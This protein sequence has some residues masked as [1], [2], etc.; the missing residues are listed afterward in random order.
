MQSNAQQTIVLPHNG[1]T[2]QETCPQGGFRHHRQ[3]YLLTPDEL[4]ATGL[5]N[6]ME[7][8]SI[9]FTIG[10]AQNIDA[11]GVLKIYLQNTG[12]EES[13][14]DTSWTQVS[15]MT[16]S[17]T[18][19]PLLRGEYE[20]QVRAVC[21]D[22][23]MYSAIATFSNTNLAGCNQP[24]DLSVTNIIDVSATLNWQSVES[25]DFSH[26]LVSYS[27]IDTADWT[28]D[29]TSLSSMNIAGLLSG[30]LYQWT[31]QAIC[32]GGFSPVSGGFFQT[33]SPIECTSPDNLSTGPISNTTAR[34]RWDEDIT[35]IRYDIQYRQLNTS[36][37]STTISFAD[38]VLLGGLSAGTYYEWRVRTVCNDG[39]GAYVSGPQFNTTGPLVCYPPNNLFETNLTDSTVT[40]HWTAPPG[41]SSYVLRYRLRNS[42]SWDN[43]IMPMTLVHNDTTV[44]PALTGN[45]T[46]PFSGLGINAFTYTGDGLYIAWEYSNPDSVIST[47]NTSLA[48]TEGTSLQNQLGLDSVE[49]ILCLAA[50]DPTMPPPVL[51]STRFRPETRLGSD[52]LSDS[53]EVVVAYTTGYH[54]IPFGNPAR[55]TAVV[56]NL[57]PLMKVLPVTVT[58][59]EKNSGALRFTETIQLDVEGDSNAL[60]VFSDWTPTIT[61]SDSVIVSIP[62]Q[63][64]ENVLINNHNSYLQV[65]NHTLLSYS[66]DSGPVTSA[67]FDTAAGLVLVRHHI[68]GCTKINAANI[69]LAPSSK[70]HSLYAVVLDADGTILSTSPA[71]IPDSTEIGTWHSFYFSNPPVLSD[72]DFYIGLAQPADNVNGYNPIGV[73]WETTVIRDSAYYRADLDGTNLTHH[74]SPGRLMIQAGVLP[75]SAVPVIE[76]DLSLCSGDMNTLTVASL[77]LRFASSVISFSSEFSNVQYSSSQVLGPPDV[78][79]GYGGD[80]NA[81]TSSTIDGQR[82]Y[83]QL[84][85]ADPAP[86][87][88]I[89][90]YETF[91]PGAVD[92]VYIRNPISGSLVAVYTATAE[93]EDP[94]SRDLTIE[95]PLTAFDVSEIRI[96][97]ASD[98]VSGFNTIDAVAIGLHESPADYASVEWSPGGEITTSIEVAAIG[99]YSVDVVDEDGCTGFAM[100]TVFTPDGVAPVIT[101]DGPVNICQGDEV[102][103]CSDQTS[104][105]TWNTGEVTQCIIV[106]SSGS[107]FVTHDDGTGCGLENSNTIVVQVNALP[108]VTI[109][110]D[111]LLCPGA[112]NT[113]D[114]GSYSS[115][116]WSTGDLTQTIM[117]SAPGEYTVTVTDANGCQGAGTVH[118]IDAPELTV[119]ITGDLTFCLGSST[120]LDA[121]MYSEYD[122]STGAM[123][124]TITVMSSGNYSVT[125]TDANGCSGSAS[126]TITGFIPPSPVITG[127]SGFCPGGET[128]LNAGPGYVLYAWSTS[129]NTQMITVDAAGTYTV[130]VTDN[131]SCTGTDNQNIIEFTPPEPVI[132]GT[133]SFC[134]GSATQL[135]AGPGYQSYL[136]STGDISQTIVVDTVDTFYVTVTDNNGCSGTDSAT[137]TDEG[138]IPEPPGPI[139]GPSSGLC[140]ETNVEY[141][142]EPVENAAFYVWTVPAGATIVS[143]QGST[144][145]F[146]DFD[147]GFTSGNIV[148]AA[149]NA[150][151]QSPSIDPTFLTVTGT[152]SMPSSIS[153][154]VTD[155]CAGDV[156]NYST[157]PVGDATGYFW[158]VPNNAQIT[159]GQGSTGITVSFLNGFTDGIICVSAT[160]DCGSS[161]PKCITIV[162]GDM[163]GDGVLDCEDNCPATFNPNQKDKD[164]D[165]VGDACDPCNNNQQGGNCNDGDPCTVNDMLDPLCACVGTYQ[166]SDNDGVCDGLDICPGFD[167]SVDSDS[168][169]VPDG[170]DLCPGYDDLEDNNNNGLPDSCDNCQTLLV[171]AG[172]CEVVYFGYN[173]ARCT[174]LSAIPL[175][176]VAPFTYMW[177]TG[178]ITQSISVC[179]V[180]TTNYFVTVTDDLGCTG[181]D[182]VTVEAVDVRCGPSNADVEVC[183][184]DAGSNTYTTLCVKKNKV[185]MHLNHGDEL[186]ECG[187]N[188]C[189]GIYAYSSGGHNDHAELDAEFDSI[190]KEVDLGEPR[191]E[192]SVYPNPATDHIILRGS[193]DL[194][195]V[196]HWDI[197]DLRGQIL[198]R[199]QSTA[200]TKMF[201]ESLD[202]S[203]I[204]PGLYFLTIRTGDKL[205]QFRIVIIE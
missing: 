17:Y 89:I 149:S 95:L 46:I 65:V 204:G 162:E 75:G 24:E 133:L 197:I 143:G 188:P 14:R 13:R 168:D 111:L 41:V 64:G 118:V 170:C 165:G 9:G 70:N 192:F 26:Y 18:I 36:F 39:S 72:T 30:Q 196:V 108:V 90:I 130:T 171:D 150:C 163:D 121:G 107:Y 159:N 71:F 62:A 117:V 94:E 106:D 203:G 37:W 81:W 7:L 181:T 33:N 103:L 22:S 85:F 54:A 169:S 32:N 191:H 113:L 166:D 35:A 157:P 127:V 31:V 19:D 27:R 147:N 114:A 198:I 91:N 57:S 194:P 88:R 100:V 135:D 148:V 119:D 101:S 66:D 190:E 56:R 179:P 201:S 34:L 187:I 59:K 12:D 63:S 160:N 87:N 153:G 51:L 115:Y 53:V 55:I 6:G 186:G 158:T 178:A 137:T 44:I 183:H 141:S 73:Q 136:W 180:V 47:F 131:N 199:N 120:M 23:S 193:I 177:N 184:Y 104:G 45:F 123:T 128:T 76:G 92:T 82:E 99:D 202:V 176:G 4:S 97:M 124:Q 167:D 67:G 84:G 152:P 195:S 139:T 40:L 116:A 50:N 5:T 79:P 42:I 105:N 11:E 43:A 144:N 60:A 164:H 28:S 21:S 25:P 29:T 16:N 145:I 155:V 174:N 189:S 20:W 49:I 74:P 182:V 78:Y 83:L 77:D 173:P 2:T 38:S 129:E 15:V 69:F 142:I 146:L 151:G 110:G 3:L 132:S 138:A 205:T 61:E 175:S 98:D 185:Q 96:A 58:V 172:T 126:V 48:T 125:V 200:E 102:E 8:N 93:A 86:V 134:A 10:A 161:A 52:D 80:A 156:H 112:T 122:W 140:N 154:P 68:A 1:S 109:T